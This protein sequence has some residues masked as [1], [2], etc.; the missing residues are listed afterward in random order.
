MDR[1]R[2]YGIDL[3]RMISMFMVIVLH[4]CG[5]GGVLSAFQTSS[6]RFWFAW[7]L[8]ISAYCAVNCYALI[9]GYVGVDSKYRY[10]RIF[11]LWLQVIFYTVSITVLFSGLHPEVLTS[12]SVVNETAVDPGEGSGIL[13]VIFL[14]FL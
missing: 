8:E 4:L 9:S 10:S 12:D 11:L 13:D 6:K 1:K 14:Y 2:C 5:H 7:L 3:L